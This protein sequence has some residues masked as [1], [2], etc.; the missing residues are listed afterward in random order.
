MIDFKNNQKH[1][2]HLVDPSPWPIISATGSLM[3]TVGG[4]M[5]MHGY[6]GGFFFITVWF[7][8]YF[9]YD[10]LLVERCYSRSYF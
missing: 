6:S 3:L 10:V 2:F 8:N 5:F 7:F 4:V 9:V 1:S